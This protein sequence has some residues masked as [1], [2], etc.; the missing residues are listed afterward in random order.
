MPDVEQRFWSKVER[1]LF[2][3]EWKGAKTSDGY[4]SFGYQGKT[5]GAHRWAYE[6][7]VRPIPPGMDLDHL[8]R[9]RACV[10]YLAH[11][12]VVTR[13]ENILRGSGTSAQNA[14]KT[15]CP[16]GHPLTGSNLYVYPKG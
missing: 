8:C 9:N 11:L 6:R 14:R 16:S 7:Y 2:C 4:G 1:T 12:E 15:H 13:H 5:V 10:N 3:W